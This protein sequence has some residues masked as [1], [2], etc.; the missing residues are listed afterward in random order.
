MQLDGDLTKDKSPVKVV[1]IDGNDGAGKST[2]GRFLACRY[3]TSLIETDFFIKIKSKSF[4]YD[5]ENISRIIR[6]RLELDRP[7]IVE[8]I[9]LLEILERIKIP[10]DFLI[11]LKNANYDGSGTLADILRSYSERYSPQQQ[12][13]IFIKHNYEIL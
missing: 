3:N 9:K 8:G 4:S 12:A 6:K 7:V 11:Y 2:L 13:N 5:E 1:A 10:H